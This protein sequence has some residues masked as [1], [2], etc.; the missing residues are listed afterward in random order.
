MAPVFPFVAVS[1]GDFPPGIL[2][3]AGLDPALLEVFF[4]LIKSCD[5]GFI[6][7]PL[8]AQEAAP[9]HPHP[10]L[11]NFDSPTPQFPG[12]ERDSLIR[13]WNDG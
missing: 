13:N 8:S 9:L 11:R 3:L 10:V 2:G 1:G 6:L 5:S 7:S 12:S 4:Q